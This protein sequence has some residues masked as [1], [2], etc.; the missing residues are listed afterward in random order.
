[1]SDR[2]P[3][4]LS[5]LVVDDEPN[6][7]TTLAAILRDE[8]HEVTVTDTGEAAVEACACQSFDVILMDVRM[9]GI[10]GVDAFRKIRQRQEGARVILMSAYSVEELAHSAMEEGVAAFVPKPLDVEAL[11]RLIGEI[12]ATGILIVED[13]AGTAKDLGN[14][15]KEQGYRVT[16]TGSPE[17]A[18]EL[19]GQIRF[20]IAFIA[21]ELP[22]MKGVDLYLAIKRITPTVVAI[23]IA[24]Q[25]PHLEESAREAVRRTAYTFVTKPLNLDHIRDLLQRIA[26][27][28]ILGS[29]RKPSQSAAEGSGRPS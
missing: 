23:M 1:M 8:G 9:P 29:L 20:D 7:R 25:E 21:S 12:K 11:I 27:Q 16:V 2:V 22:A 26:G 5:I 13:D 24:G 6:M 10:S 28:Q 14:A 15:L 18:L 3:V 4:P 17:T 19:A